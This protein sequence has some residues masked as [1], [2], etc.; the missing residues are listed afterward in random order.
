METYSFRVYVA[1]SLRLAPQN[2]VITK[3]WVDLIRRDEDSR[4]PEQM[5]EDVLSKIG[6]EVIE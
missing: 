1:E 3:S 4:T 6:L 5:L 2:K